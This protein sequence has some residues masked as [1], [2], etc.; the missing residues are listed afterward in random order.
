MD[1]IH[2]YCFVFIHMSI[3]ARILRLI[4]SLVNLKLLWF[5]GL[6]LPLLFIHEPCVL[7]QALLC[8][9]FLRA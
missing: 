2:A 3:A 8:P 9:L 5:Y 6:T 1:S 4:L 7:G